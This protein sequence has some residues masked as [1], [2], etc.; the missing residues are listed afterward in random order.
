M[1]HRVT[2]EY[3]YKSVYTARVTLNNGGRN[4]RVGDS[5]TVQMSGKTYTITVEGRRPLD[6]GYASEANVN[7]TTRSEYREWHP[8]RWWNCIGPYTTDINALA[9]LPP[10]RPSVTSS[11]LNV[12]TVGTSTSKPKV[13]QSTTPCTASSQVCQ[14]HHPAA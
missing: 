7:H 2:H 3:T 8:G 12:Q 14:R 13:V 4:W 6:I 9:E 5:I 11:T 1:F 10:P